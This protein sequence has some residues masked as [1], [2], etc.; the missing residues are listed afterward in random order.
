MFRYTVKYAES[1][2][3]IQISIYYTK[4]TNNAKT[5]SIFCK[6][7]ERFEKCTIFNF[8]FYYLYKFHNSCFEMFG[9]VVFL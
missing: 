6:Y 1:E 7:L 8:V 2:Y 4:Y 3:D 9:I 5:L